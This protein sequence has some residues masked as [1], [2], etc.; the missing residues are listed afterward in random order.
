MCLKLDIAQCKHWLNAR[1]FESLLTA[2]HTLCMYYIGFL[3]VESLRAA[4]Y[5]LRQHGL[6]TAVA[7]YYSIYI[8]TYIGIYIYIY[9]HIHNYTYN[10]YT[11]CACWDQYATE[12]TSVVCTPR[13]P[14]FR[15]RRVVINV[16]HA[17]AKPWSC[18]HRRV[19]CNLPLTA[20]VLWR[21]GAKTNNVS[22]YIY[23][24]IYMY[25]HIITHQYMCMCMYIYIYIYM[26]MY[27]YIDIYIY[28]Y[29]YV[30]THTYMYIHICIHID[31]M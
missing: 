22:L 24:Y 23:I 4:P 14:C 1:K 2:I 29:I 25:T 27:I 19:Y 8:Y 20:R 6:F 31:L 26:N 12:T 21:T 5:T 16:L 7:V 10:I 17:T 9:I 15:S 11:L 3:G 28:I 13:V 18:G 30:Y